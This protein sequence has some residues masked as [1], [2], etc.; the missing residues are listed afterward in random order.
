MAEAKAITKTVLTDPQTKTQELNVV[1]SRINDRL[2][3][4]FKQETDRTPII[5]PILIEAS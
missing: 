4:F 5:L 1:K 2:A 3:K